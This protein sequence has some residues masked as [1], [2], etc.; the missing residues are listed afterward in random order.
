MTEQ[1]A[2]HMAPEPDVTGCATKHAYQHLEVYH[3]THQLLPF[4]GPGNN[5]HIIHTLQ[6]KQALHDSA[7]T[8]PTAPTAYT[9]Y[10]E[11]A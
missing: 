11:A 7:P 4:C 1:A 6:R 2:W 10:L 3:H 5:L 9:N 8:A